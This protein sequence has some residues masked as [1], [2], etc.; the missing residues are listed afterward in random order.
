MRLLARQ[1]SIR[2]KLTKEFVQTRLIPKLDAIIRN[3]DGQIKAYHLYPEFDPK[4]NGLA[5]RNEPSGYSY[6]F[7]N[8]PIVYSGIEIGMMEVKVPWMLQE[9]WKGL[10]IPL[11]L[12][13]NRRD[14]SLEKILRNKPDQAA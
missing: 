14:Q 9:C 11:N 12:L 8:T 13:A 2:G 6:K 10:G 1:Y 7:G 4:A 5:R 3:S